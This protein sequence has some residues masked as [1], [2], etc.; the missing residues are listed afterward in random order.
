VTRTSPVFLRKTSQFIQQLKATGQ[1]VIL[2]VNGKA[3]LVVQDAKSYQKLLELVDRLEAI[4]AIREG[5]QDEAEGRVVTLEEAMHLAV[6]HSAR[7]PLPP[8]ALV[9]DAG[10]G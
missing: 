9:E 8:D 3:E 6:W 1:P 5:L 4:E 7:Q 10:Q 2:T